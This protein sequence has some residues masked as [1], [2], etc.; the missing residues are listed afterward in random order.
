MLNFFKSVYFLLI[1]I[2]CIKHIKT[3]Y[4]DLHY[5]YQVHYTIDNDM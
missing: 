2:M 4:Q 1:A 3:A 5:F